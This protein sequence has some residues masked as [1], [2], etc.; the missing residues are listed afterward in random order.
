MDE[1]DYYFQL[2]ENFRM[3]KDCYSVL[4][5]E[6]S[7]MICLEWFYKLREHR[8]RFYISGLS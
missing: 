3:F 4:P 5:D 8:I 6:N 7:Y 2:L 1:K